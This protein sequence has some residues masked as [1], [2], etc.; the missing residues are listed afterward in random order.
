MALIDVNWK[1]GSR[2]LR[3]F[4]GLFLIFGLGAGTLIYFFKDWPLWVSQALWVAAVVVGVL[5][6]IVP[7]VARPVYIVMMALALPVGMVVSTVLMTLIFFVV[8]TPI[9]VLMRLVGKDS[10]HKKFDPDATTY[11]IRR[12][13]QVPAARYFKQY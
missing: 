12:P 7:A 13:P 4:A 10:M 3:Q 9:G 2:E 1:P 11:W 6:L 8:I 5:G